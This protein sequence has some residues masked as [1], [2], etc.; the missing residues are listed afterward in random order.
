MF[1]RHVCNAN[2][3]VGFEGKLRPLLT[4]TKLMQE[5]L[6]Q[7]LGLRLEELL[8]AGVSEFSSVTRAPL[9]SVRIKPLVFGGIS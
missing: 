9:E 1:Q 8:Q 3:L 2:N 7:A 4:T 6:F 5:E